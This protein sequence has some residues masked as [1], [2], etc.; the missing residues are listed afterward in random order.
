MYRHFFGTDGV[1]GH[2]GDVPIT[3]ELVLKLGWAAG[4]TL[5]ASDRGRGER[6]TVLI[7]KD[8]RLSGY[9][10]EAALEAG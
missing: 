5:A 10:L 8:T 7:G 9:L 4:R 1:R 3:P 2:V 6:P